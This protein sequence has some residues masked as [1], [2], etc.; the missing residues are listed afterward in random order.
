MSLSE[1]PSGD[2]VIYKDWG[3][4][5]HYFLT[6]FRPLHAEVSLYDDNLADFCYERLGLFPGD[7]VLDAGCGAGDVAQRLA[8]RGIK[9]TG[10]DLSSELIDHCRKVADTSSFPSGNA[11]FQVED[12]RLPIPLEKFNAVICLGVTFGYFEDSI[13][14]ACFQNLARLLPK[15][16]KLLIESDDPFSLEEGWIEQEFRLKVDLET[17]CT[18]QHS[19]TVPATLCLRRRFVK[20][21]SSYEGFFHL[22]LGDGR[23]IVLSQT[24]NQNYDGNRVCDERIRIYSKE[25]LSEMAVHSG[26]VLEAVYGDSV[27]PEIDYIPGHSRRLVTQFFRP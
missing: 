21:T 3:W 25:E 2:S 7:R 26:L 1:C 19:Q 6:E 20:Q 18:N 5:S 27:L 23:R 13:N 14:R 11:V 15:G 10:I 12:I 4:W 9:V 17:I 22:E 24:L 16:G 8:L